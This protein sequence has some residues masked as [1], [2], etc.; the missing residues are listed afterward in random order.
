MALYMMPSFPSAE[1][2]DA[3]YALLPRVLSVGFRDPKIR[4]VAEAID[5]KR[6][7]IVLKLD[8]DT[9]GLIAA[10]G[11]AAY[12]YVVL[13]DSDLLR[14][15]TEASIATLR[16]ELAALRARG[17][18]GL[19][20]WTKDVTIRLE[21]FPVPAGEK[22]AARG[23]LDAAILAAFKN[24]EMLT[25]VSKMN[26]PVDVVTLV[27]DADATEFIAARGQCPYEIRVWPEE[28]FLATVRG[29]TR[30]AMRDVLAEARKVGEVAVSAILRDG[31]SLFTSVRLKVPELFVEVPGAVD[32]N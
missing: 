9:P 25:T 31:T 4:G 24:P 26:R 29:D 21:G 15:F 13:R 28:T 32:N 10:E 19:V 23:M 12:D 27:I 7:V 14:G 1:Q 3:A 2:R 18:Y 22:E 5:T 11:V 6:A 16:A 30:D 17:E 20:A 8:V